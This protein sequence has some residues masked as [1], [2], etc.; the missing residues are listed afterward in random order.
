MYSFA[1][2]NV[3]LYSLRLT[4]KFVSRIFIY[5]QCIRVCHGV[6]LLTT[7]STAQQNVHEI[8]WRKR[9]PLWNQRTTD[10]D[11]AGP[12]K[13]LSNVIYSFR[14]ALSYSSSKYLLLPPP[15]PCVQCAHKYNTYIH[16]YM[17]NRIR[18][19]PPVF[20]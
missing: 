15:L 9:K 17:Y 3:K 4:R 10:D 2:S 7:I 5:I 13:S 18:Q 12:W 6:D 19:F 16:K 8:L 11:D 14:V 20:F 1:H